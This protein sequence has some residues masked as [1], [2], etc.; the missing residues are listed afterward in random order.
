LNQLIF[1]NTIDDS[2]LVLYGAG[3]SYTCAAYVPVIEI[4][5]EKT[6]IDQYLYGYIASCEDEARYITA[7]FNS[8]ALVSIISEFQSEGAFGPRHIHKLPCDVTPMFNKNNKLHVCVADIARR[9]VNNLSAVLPDS[10]AAKY[11]T[12]SKSNI[13]TRRR[14]IREVIYSLS[15]YSDY[16][17]ACREAFMESGH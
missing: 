15:E 16:E 12:P 9:L 6:V 8:Q 7:M 4:N 13:Q 17:E 5:I 14:K 1:P 10:D 11:I 2:H 3:G